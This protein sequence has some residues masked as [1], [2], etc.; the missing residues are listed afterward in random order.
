VAQ[1]AVA[2]REEK[3]SVYVLNRLSL[4]RS[5]NTCVCVCV[6]VRDCVCVYVCARGRRSIDA[7]GLQYARCVRVY[8]PTHART[9]AYLYVHVHI[10]V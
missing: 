8:T 6:C 3:E 10:C 5:I 1:Y 4:S 9:H 7:R 2:S